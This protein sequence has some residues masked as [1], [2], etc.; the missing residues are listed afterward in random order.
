MND[1]Y[2]HAPEK[3][4]GCDAQVRYYQPLLGK[5]RYLGEDGEPHTCPTKPELVTVDLR[6]H[7]RGGSIEPVSYTFEKCSDPEAEAL[8]QFRLA[9]TGPRRGVSLNILPLDAVALYNGTTLR[10][11]IYVADIAGVSVA[12]VRGER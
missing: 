5:G 4:V 11:W 2:L 3:C 10:G 9:M 12:S 8:R 6:V 7:L 1:E